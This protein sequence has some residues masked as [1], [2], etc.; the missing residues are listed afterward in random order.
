MSRVSA[1]AGV[2]CLGSVLAKGGDGGKVGMT[3][4]AEDAHGRVG[5]LLGVV[6]S[7]SFLLMDE[8]SPRGEVRHWSFVVEKDG[9]GSIMVKAGDGAEVQADGALL[10]ELQQVIERFDLAALNGTDRVV[11]GLPPM[12]GPCRLNVVYASGERLY[13]QKNSIPQEGWPKVML[14]ILLE[15]SG[16]TL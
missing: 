6:L 13:F 1:T 14:D 16:K 9:S 8:A 11:A 15:A 5:S 7:T 3:L 10:S 4:G 12:F 2:V